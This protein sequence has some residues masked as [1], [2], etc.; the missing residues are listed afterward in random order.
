MAEQLRNPMHYLITLLFCALFLTNAARAENRHALIIS[1][2]EYGSD[3]GRLENP[4]NDAVLMQSALESI[5]FDVEIVQNANRAGMLRA[6]KAHR[7]KLHSAGEDAVSFFYYSGHGAADAQA[8]QNYLVPIAAEIQIPEDLDISAV[9][10]R[11]FV[12]AFSQA[13]YNFVVIDACRNFPFPSASSR[14]IQKGFVPQP[15]EQGTLIAFATAPG[16]TASDAGVN[17]GPYAR[18]LSKRISEPGSDHVRTFK[19][20]QTDV[21]N[22]TGRVQF[23]WY[24]D[25]VPGY[26]NFSSGEA[27]ATP[28]VTAISTN[29]PSAGVT[30][31]LPANRDYVD[32][33]T[34]TVDTAAPLIRTDPANLPDFALFKECYSCPDMVVLPAGTFKWQ[35]IAQARQVSGPLREAPVERFAIARFEL[36][37]PQWTSC[38]E[39]NHCSSDDPYYDFS[40]RQTL[41]FIIASEV[42]SLENP[43][44]SSIELN[45]YL[46]FIQNKA[47][48][49]YRLPSEAEWVYAS[50]AGAETQYYW[51]NEPPSCDPAA[52]NGASISECRL[53]EPPYALPMGTFK[54]NGFGLYD[55]FGGVRE[56]TRAC[57]KDRDIRISNSCDEYVMRGGDDHFLR[58]WQPSI[59]QVDEREPNSFW[60]GGIRLAR[61]LGPAP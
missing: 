13:Q 27:S 54:S 21:Y 33:R 18:A 16:R 3:I 48:S 41:P 52:A 14:S 19:N 53:E 55:M 35:T 12:N 47:N 58:N 7:D 8:N 25:G 37:R 50:L 31:N 46:S 51:G 11:N 45:A 34:A 29:P 60:F 42:L 38:V 22:E 57:G 56:I 43:D 23:P 44:G 24:E 49:A 28:A 40:I 9:P 36:S 61:S 5:G 10:L 17:G 2:S 32:A 6:L 26:F 15:K 39:A 59:G 4:K 1:N 30:K 20:V